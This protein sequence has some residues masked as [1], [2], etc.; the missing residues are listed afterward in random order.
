MKYTYWID[1]QGGRHYHKEDCAMVR[2]PNYHYEPII[3]TKDREF[4]REW[5]LTRIRES[6]KYYVA[7]FGCF[8][9]RRK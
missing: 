2:D 3:R 4:D 8:G 5:G 7:D 9:E 1:R 6:G